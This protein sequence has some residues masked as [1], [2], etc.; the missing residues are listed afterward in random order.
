MVQSQRVSW[1]CLEEHDLV[2]WKH[3][4]VHVTQTHTQPLAQRAE[5]TEGVGKKRREREREREEREKE[6][7]RERE[8]KRKREREREGE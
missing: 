2:L 8:R 1:L 5:E 7:E 6:K 4:D 3:R